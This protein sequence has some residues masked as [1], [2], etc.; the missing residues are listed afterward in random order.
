MTHFDASVRPQDDFFGYINN[1]WLSANPIPNTETT[2][3]TFYVLRDKSW[4]AVDEIVKDLTK[5]KE[6]KLSRDQKLL[7]NFFASSLNFEKHSQEQAAT[8]NHLLDTVDAVVNLEDLAHTLGLLHRLDISAFWTLYVSQDERDSSNQVLRFY[9]SGLGLPNRDYYLDRSKRM[10][11]YRKAYAEYFNDF[12]TTASDF[13]LSPWTAVWKLEKQLAEVS[14]TDVA[15]RDV[16]KNYARLTQASIKKQIPGFD[17]TS[18]WCGLGWQNPTD[19]IVIDQLSFVQSCVKLL[20]ESTLKDIKAYLKWQIVNS[21]ASWTSKQLAELSFD[22]YGKTLSGQKEMKPLWKR[23]V[24]LADRLIIG[25]ALG[26]EYAARHFPESSKKAVQGLVED[27]RKAYHARMDRLTWMSE[28]TKK[29]AHKKLDNIQVF[30]GYPTVWKDLSRLDFSEHDVVS[31]ILAARVH[32]S[33][34]ELAKIGKKPAD[35]EWEMNAHTVNAYNHPNRLEIVFPAA[36]LQAPFYDPKATHAA[37]LGGIGAV[38]GHELTH[39]FD[40]EG[41]KFDEFGNVNPWQTKAESKAFDKLAENIVHQADTFETVPGTFLQGR[42]ILGEA[43]ADVGGLSLAVEALVSQKP[44][45]LKDLFVN[46]ATCECGQATPERLVELAKTDPHPPSPF[47]VNCVV[48]HVD[49]FYE[50]YDVKPTDKLYLPPE[51]RAKIW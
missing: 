41:S 45:E 5:S 12:K 40:D 29:I 47:R 44:D 38:I 50:T 24:L 51:N 6:E 28:N 11:T 4:E 10:V 23:T 46:F 14:W 3:G 32:A 20:N 18:Y 9:Q 43:I 42:L 36:I 21:Y 26:R 13:T 27:I 25:E 35:E 30:V 16:E 37:N 17:W 15:L 33:D 2:W 1:S 22:F 31:N 49:A 8:V 34:I 48:N 7:K 19:N 39:S